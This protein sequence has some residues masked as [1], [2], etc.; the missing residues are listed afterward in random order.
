ML[1]QTK[2]GHHTITARGVEVLGQNLESIDNRFLKQLRES[3]KPSDINP[4][5]ENPP[6]PP[7][8]TQDDVQLNFTEDEQT[9]LKAIET[10]SSHIDTIARTTQLPIAKVSSLLS[11]LELKG[12]VEQ[13][14]GKQFGKVDRGMTPGPLH[15]GGATVVERQSKHLGESSTP[16]SSHETN[17]SEP[18]TPSPAPSENENT[19]FAVVETHSVNVGTLGHT[20]QEPMVIATAIQTAWDPVKKKNAS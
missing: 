19:P 14:P 2:R 15:E 4:T 3:V 20:A 10:P 11:M 6:L 12:I 7:L 9:L 8:G 13:M 16:R 17:E 1:E 5:P 18:V